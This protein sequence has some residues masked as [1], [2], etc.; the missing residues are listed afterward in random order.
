MKTNS[1]CAAFAVQARTIATTRHLFI[2]RACLRTG[3]LAF[4]TIA[5]GLQSAQAALAEAWVQRYG[6]ETGSEDYV[7]KIVTDAAGNVIV[8]GTSM[9]NGSGSGMVVIKYSGKGVPLWTNRYNGPAPRRAD[10]FLPALVR[11]ATWPG[12]NWSEPALQTD[13][14]P[15]SD[16]KNR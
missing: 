9:H 12:P 2:R 3:F 6:S 1:I 16:N 7:Y 14:A 13:A 10:H 5:L 8:A 15:E 4:A 11:H